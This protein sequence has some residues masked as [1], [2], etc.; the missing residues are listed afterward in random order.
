M[1][2]VIVNSICASVYLLLV[3]LDFHNNLNAAQGGSPLRFIVGGINAS[4]AGSQ[5]VLPGLCIAAAWCVLM[6]FSRPI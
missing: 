5:I 3:Y 1:V 4:L 2:G 6:Y